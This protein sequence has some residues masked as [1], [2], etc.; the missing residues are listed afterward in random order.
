MTPPRPRLE[1]FPPTPILAEILKKDEQ[2]ARSP[3]WLTALRLLLAALVILALDFVLTSFM[4]T[5]V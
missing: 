5:G 4:F 2:P 3:W 1:A